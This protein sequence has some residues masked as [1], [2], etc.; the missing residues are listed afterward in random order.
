MARVVSALAI[1]LACV[2]AARPLPIRAQDAA[3]PPPPRI[4]PSERLP[5]ASPPRAQEPAPLPP[6]PAIGVARPP[7]AARL[8]PL[9]EERDASD[10]IVVIG[11]GWRLPDLGSRWRQQQ[12]EAA[13]EDGPHVTFLPLYDPDRQM[14][15]NDT[16]WLSREAQRQGYIELFRLNFG[17]RSSEDKPQE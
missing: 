15:R 13:S 11:K 16:F 2:A 10:E 7:N 14:P 4:I 17:R 9:P 6:V 5:V 3:V 12:E 8:A 1:G